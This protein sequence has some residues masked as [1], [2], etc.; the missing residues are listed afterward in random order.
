MG[1]Y[2]SIVTCRNSQENI[3]S[4][5]L[6]IK[7]QTLGPEYVIVVDDGST[8]G[9]AGILQRMQK[10]WGILRVITNPDLGYDIGRVVSNW[11][12]AIRFASESNLPKTD[13]HIIC[14]YDTE[15]ERDY[16]E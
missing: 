7:G 6:S 2:F 11:N 1:T 14:T 4:S 12:K 13:Y 10:E 9:T 3:E 16:A 5:L 15:Y 8:D